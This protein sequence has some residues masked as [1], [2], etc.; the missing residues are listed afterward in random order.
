MLGFLS[1]KVLRRKIHDSQEDSLVFFVKKQYLQ[2]L[3]VIIVFIILQRYESFFTKMQTTWYNMSL[4]NEVVLLIGQGV[5]HL[6]QMSNSK[7]VGK[8]STS[9]FKLWQLSGNYVV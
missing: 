2:T 9:M 5:V 4:K 1:L 3:M 6:V 8:T 7:R